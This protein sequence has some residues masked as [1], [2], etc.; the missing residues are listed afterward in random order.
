MSK[1]DEIVQMI[2]NINIKYPTS[3][4]LY[5]NEFALI[6]LFDMKTYN[7]Y[8]SCDH[9]TIIRGAEENISLYNSIIVSIIKIFQSNETYNFSGLNERCKM[10]T[11]KIIRIF[12]Q[13]YG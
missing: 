1:L 9:D 11:K 6:M 3:S 8:Y 2:N 13:I 4:E 12:L 5:I 7:E 10:L